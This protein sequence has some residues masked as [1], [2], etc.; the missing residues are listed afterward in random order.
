MQVKFLKD[1]IKANMSIIY[2]LLNTPMIE[3][4]QIN[5]LHYPMINKNNVELRQRIKL[6]RKETLQ[7]EKLINGEGIR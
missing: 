7:L 5:G 4:K 3:Q 2:D 6:L 1:S